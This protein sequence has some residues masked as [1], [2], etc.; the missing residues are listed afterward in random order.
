[1]WGTVNNVNASLLTAISVTGDHEK[2]GSYMRRVIREWPISCENALTDMSINRKAWVGHAA[3][4]LGFQIPENIV[5]K[6]WGIITNE[7]RK[8]ANAQAVH[9][10]ELW[11]LDNTEN[12]SLYQQMGKQVLLWRHSR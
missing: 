5:R 7:Q 12:T 8:L 2:Y 9:A 11:E 6:A 1:M 4:A 3:M 10:I